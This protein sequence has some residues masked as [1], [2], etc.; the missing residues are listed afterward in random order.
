MFELAQNPDVVE[1]MYHEVLDVC[2]AE[3]DVTWDHV[4][5]LKYI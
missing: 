1:K 5:E 4:H 2:G 3:G